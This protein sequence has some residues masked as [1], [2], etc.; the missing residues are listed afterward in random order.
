[1]VLSSPMRVQQLI[2]QERRLSVAEAR[3]I[4]SL[5][6][7]GGPLSNVDKLRPVGHHAMTPT[8]EATEATGQRPGREMGSSLSSRFAAL[9]RKSGNTRKETRA[10]ARSLVG[11]RINLGEGSGGD[12]SAG[13]AS[14]VVS[15]TCLLP[16]QR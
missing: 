16:L 8:W 11:R 1:M 5:P 7:E 12:G 9:A 15:Q 14:A 4:V 2:N 6:P 3:L 10:H 13:G